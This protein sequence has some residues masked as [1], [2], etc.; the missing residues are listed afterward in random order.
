MLAA[1]SQEHFSHRP[2]GRV[3]DFW[4]PWCGPCLAMAPFFENTARQLEP[5]LRFAKLDTEERSNRVRPP[6][7]RDDASNRKDTANS[8]A[9]S[10]ATKNRFAR[11]YGIPLWRVRNWTAKP[12]KIRAVSV[13]AVRR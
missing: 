11:P 9:N 5:K 6:Y 2:R 8:H 10:T 3:V 1:A 12:S 7:S 4:A 13:Q